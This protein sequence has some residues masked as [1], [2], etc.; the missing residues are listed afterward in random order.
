MKAFD[1]AEWIPGVRNVAT[2]ILTKRV[3]QLIA[4]YGHARFTTD[5]AK[6]R[7]TAKAA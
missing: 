2:W 6:Y 7:P 5:A 3:E 4:S 1:L